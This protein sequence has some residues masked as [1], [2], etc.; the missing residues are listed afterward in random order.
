MRSVPCCSRTHRAETPPRVQASD[1][2]P[3][4]ADGL[5]IRELRAGVRSFTA[6]SHWDNRGAIALAR[7]L[8]SCLDVTGRNGVAELLVN[9]HRH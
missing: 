5:L 1:P 9:L 8:D 4:D 3:R 7:K 2:Q 6:T